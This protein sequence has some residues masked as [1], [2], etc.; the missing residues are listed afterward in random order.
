[1]PE[2]NEHERQ[3][4]HNLL[5][6]IDEALKNL[7]EDVR[8]VQGKIDMLTEDRAKLIGICV[9]V[10]ATVSIVVKIFWPGK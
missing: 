10:A 9:G 7:K 6:R 1:M 4:D 8:I 2:Q 3:A 5:I